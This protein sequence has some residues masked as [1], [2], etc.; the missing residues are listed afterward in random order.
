MY[1]YLQYL[2]ERDEFWGKNN[3]YK[4]TCFNGFVDVDSESKHK[5]WVNKNNKNFG[6]NWVKFL[7]DGSKIILK[8]KQFQE[9][10]RRLLR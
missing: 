7:E 6:S 4:D 8:K 3:F 10:V 5:E 9:S 1:T 2:C